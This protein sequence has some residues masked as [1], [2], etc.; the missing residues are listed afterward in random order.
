MF[1]AQSGDWDFSRP[2]L[3]CGLAKHSPDHA[4]GAPSATTFSGTSMKSRRDRRAATPQGLL[5]V[6]SS[7]RRFTCIQGLPAPTVP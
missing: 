4:E 6:W 7:Q 5:A 1:G 2:A 3:R